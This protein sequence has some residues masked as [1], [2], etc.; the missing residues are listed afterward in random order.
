MSPERF[1]LARKV[2][3]DRE[4]FDWTYAIL[5]IVHDC[6]RSKIA[7]L[8]RDYRKWRA[9]QVAYTQMRLW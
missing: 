6:T 3:E 4:E 2:Y 8:L 9:G 7:G 5:G 1:A